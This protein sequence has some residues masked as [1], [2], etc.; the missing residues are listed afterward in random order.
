MHTA[1]LY[2]PERLS[3]LL[4]LLLPLLL[5]AAVLF[6]LYH[7]LPRQK[8]RIETPYA[9][10]KIT[11]PNRIGAIRQTFIVREDA[12]CGIA[13][14][15]TP[16]SPQPGAAVLVQLQ[17]DAGRV[18]T[19]QTVALAY[20]DKSRFVRVSFTPVEHAKGRRFTLELRP[21]QGQWMDGA[22]FY[23]QERDE[24]GYRLYLDGTQ[25]KGVLAFRT[26]YRS[27]RL[28]AIYNGRFPASYVTLVLCVIAVSVVLCCLL[29]GLLLKS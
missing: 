16:D 20:V 2:L 15:I 22:V 19:R 13:V 24:T 21:A 10:S 14:K 18:V 23:R 8:T 11:V 5:A 26:V 25:Q 6:A 9:L 7:E 28:G 27:S 17:D 4:P 3:R 29:F 1:R 12:F